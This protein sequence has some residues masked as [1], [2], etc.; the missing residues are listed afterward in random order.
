MALEEKSNYLSLL[1]TLIS[2]EEISFTRVSKLQAIEY[3][4]LEL[5]FSFWQYG[6]DCDAIP[7][8]GS[9]EDRFNYLNELVGFDFYSD[10]SIEYY[11]PAFYQFMTENGYYGYAHDHLE[12]YVD[13]VTDFTNLNFAPQEV[14]L[15]Y[16][17][18]Y[19]KYVRVYLYHHGDKVLY[20]HGGLDP[21]SACKITPSKKTDALVMIDPDG[22]HKTRISSFD[23]A[24]KKLIYN[25]LE[26]WI[27]KHIV[28]N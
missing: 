10:E 18:E 2:S 25:T 4:I 24:D 16:N 14:A 23:E 28:N 9:F 8:E 3:T 27:G 13:Y 6:H 26:K 7:L 20:I 17:Q 11:E 15:N 5:T 21:W 19:L 12:G 1:D 22:D